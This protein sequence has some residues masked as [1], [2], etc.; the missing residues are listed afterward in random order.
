M[1]SVF[2]PFLKQYL[3]LESFCSTHCQLSHRIQFSV[4]SCRLDEPKQC[5]LFLFFS[6]RSDF[7]TVL[8]VWYIC[9]TH[10]EWSTFHTSTTSRIASHSFPVSFSRIFTLLKFSKRIYRSKDGES[11]K[12][13]EGL[14][15]IQT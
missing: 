15:S 12:Y 10:F 9:R 1:K 14:D 6:C 11:H 5:G 13:K 8:P 2:N 3:L 7:S 4:S